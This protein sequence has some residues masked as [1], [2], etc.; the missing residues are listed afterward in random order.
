MMVAVDCCSTDN[1]S[2]AECVPG[3][4]IPVKRVTYTSS[5][6]STVQPALFFAPKT[7]SPV[8]LLV[9]L[10]SWSFDYTQPDDVPYAQWCIENNWAFM[11]PNFRGKNN[12]PGTTGS[13]LVIA[14]VVSAVEYAKNCANIDKNRIYLVG[15]SGGGYTALLVAGKE[16][17]IWAAV[18]AWCPIIDLK[19]WYYERKNAGG[20]FERYAD[21][22]AAS[23]GGAP[24]GSPAVDAE[25]QKRSPI[26]YL[27]NAKAV[28]LDLNAGIRDGHVGSVAINHTLRAFN[29]LADEKDRISEEDIQYFVGKTQVPPHLT[30]QV[31]DSTYGD[32]TA[33]FR[34]TS[35]NARVTIFDGEHEI[36]HKAALAWLA[37]QNKQN[38]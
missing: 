31:A 15:Q 35:G 34:R 4:P 37:K 29:I 17:N 33:L 8:P 30:R 28:P 23:C 2:K 38:P 26:T 14:D 32:K 18:S 19:A 24:G 9:A 36:I 1:T 6:D 20:E 11:H 10:H 7:K 3:W 16:P 5:A 21:E 12:N 25:Y 27:A 22:I 13:N